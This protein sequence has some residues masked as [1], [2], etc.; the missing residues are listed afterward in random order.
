MRFAL[1][2][3]RAAT[4]KR[5]LLQLYA[6][7]MA[8]QADVK[9]LVRAAAETAIVLDSWKPSRMHSWLHQINRRRCTRSGQRSPFYFAKGTGWR[10]SLRSPAHCACALD[11][12]NRMAVVLAGRLVSVM[13]IAEL[14]AREVAGAEV[15]TVEDL[16]G[17]GVEAESPPR[18]S[19]TKQLVR[20]RTQ[21]CL[22]DEL[23]TFRFANRSA[24]RQWLRSTRGHHTCWPRGRAC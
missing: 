5:L 15:E 1:P 11:R 20:S 21:C 8:V 10:K 4:T 2:C 22:F 9:A 24:R 3:T 12:Q 23:S 17:E 7:T 19:K 16:V 14:A 13:G 18:A 6:E